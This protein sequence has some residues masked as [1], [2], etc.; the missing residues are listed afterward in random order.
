MKYIKFMMMAL[1]MCLTAISCTEM[2]EG[3]VKS[4]ADEFIKK[5]FVKNL[6]F[7][8]SYEAISTNIISKGSG[9]NT[10]SKSNEWVIEHS[11]KAMNGLG[12]IIPGKVVLKYQP[13]SNS[14]NFEIESYTK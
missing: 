12:M 3:K 2:V 8:E 9:G 13:N 10:M 4:K 7:P 6:K 14:E 5:E 11:Y 1:M